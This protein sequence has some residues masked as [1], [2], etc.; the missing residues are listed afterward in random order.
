MLA[1]TC[2]ATV[3]QKTQVKRA[4]GFFNFT[5]SEGFQT[6]SSEHLMDLLEYFSDFTSGLQMK[7]LLY[8]LEKGFLP[9]SPQACGEEPAVWGCCV[10]GPAP[11]VPHCASA[12]AVLVCLALLCVTQTPDLR[13]HPASR[14]F[15]VP[16]GLVL[17]TPPWVLPPFHCCPTSGGH[18]APRLSDCP[19]QQSLF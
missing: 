4:C 2:L 12:E 3:L 8:L 1:L 19:S 14:V 5:S 16:L 7:V 6:A 9:S 11:P 15:T 17:L 18:G 10:L 13:S